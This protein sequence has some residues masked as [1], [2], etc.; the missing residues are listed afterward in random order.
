MA[1]ESKSSMLPNSKLTIEEEV[2]AALEYLQEGNRISGFATDAID[3][4]IADVCFVRIE[5]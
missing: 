4:D 3:N 5:Y 1:V 2:V